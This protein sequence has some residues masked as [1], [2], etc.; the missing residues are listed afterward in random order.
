MLL[1][2]TISLRAVNAEADAV[3]GLSKTLEEIKTRATLPRL[4]VDLLSAANH[5]FLHALMLNR[6]SLSI[7]ADERSRTYWHTIVKNHA[8]QTAGRT[9]T[10]PSVGPVP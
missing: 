3:I 7:T 2:V 5:N 8:K 9:L 6:R 10:V 1:G 4:Q